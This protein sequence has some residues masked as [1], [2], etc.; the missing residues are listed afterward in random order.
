M[1]VDTGHTMGLTRA[2][3]AAALRG[4]PA[5]EPA[6]TTSWSWDKPDTRPAAWAASGEDK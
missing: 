4:T 2:E 1:S 5:D 3:I 6:P